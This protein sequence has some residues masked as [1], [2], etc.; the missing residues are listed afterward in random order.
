[1]LVRPSSWVCHFFSSAV[2]LGSAGARNRIEKGMVLGLARE[3]VGPMSLLE[4]CTATSSA[5]LG[6]SVRY[7]HSAK[8]SVVH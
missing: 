8:P 7:A 4:S 1:M 2:R 5:V 6:I 3:C